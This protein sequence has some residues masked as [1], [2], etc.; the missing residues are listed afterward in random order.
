MLGLYLET[1]QDSFLTNPAPFSSTRVLLCLSARCSLYCVLVQTKNHWTSFE[2]ISLVK[3]WRESEGNLQKSCLGALYPEPPMP[4]WR[5][6]DQAQLTAP[7]NWHSFDKFLTPWDWCEDCPALI[8]S[9]DKTNRTLIRFYGQEIGLHSY[10]RIS[11]PLLFTPS[12]PSC[13]QALVSVY[14]SAFL[15]ISCPLTL[16]PFSIQQ[17][18][19]SGERKLLKIAVHPHTHTHI[20]TLNELGDAKNWVDWKYAPVSGNYKCEDNFVSQ[21][22]LCRTPWCSTLRAL[23]RRKMSIFYSE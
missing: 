20:Q 11:L 7:Y 10:F 15:F 9:S 19:C 18:W 12:I 16:F 21:Q 22:E 4:H 14:N 5:H 6:A 2:K 8:E 17:E 13:M 23:T 3:K 1:D